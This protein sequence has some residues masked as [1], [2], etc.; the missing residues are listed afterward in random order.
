MRAAALRFVPQC[1]NFNVG[2]VIT[3]NYS[4]TRRVKIGKVP[5]YECGGDS[6]CVDDF[7][8]YSE[9][10]T[11]NV[12]SFVISSLERCSFNEAQKQYAKSILFKGGK[13]HE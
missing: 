13:W 4:Q 1:P 5:I 6:E 12:I 2:R 8:R 3:Y 11:E 9:Q 7:C 10:E